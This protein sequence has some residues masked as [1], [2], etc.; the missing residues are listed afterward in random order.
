MVD[1]TE[2]TAA[3]EEVR[4]GELLAEWAELR[5]KLEHHADLLQ[6]VAID[7]QKTKTANTFMA[8]ANRNKDA[9]IA[10]LKQQ[11]KDAG[12]EPDDDEAPNQQQQSF[13]ELD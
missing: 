7:L 4:V 3:H 5:G 8:S 11:L 2:P 9:Q 13:V 10:R 6:K 1:N 12:L